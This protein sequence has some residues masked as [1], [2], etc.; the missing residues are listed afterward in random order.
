MM[1]LN[2]FG[3]FHQQTSI[4][5]ERLATGGLFLITGPTGSGKTTIFDA[6]T[7]ALYGSTS[8]E[9]RESDSLKSHYA[10]DEEVS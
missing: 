5:F 9:V 3:P 10:S 8:G 1:T 6:L 2:A 7:F 4:D